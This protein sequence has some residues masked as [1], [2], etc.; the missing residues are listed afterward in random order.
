MSQGENKSTRFNSRAASSNLPNTYAIHD[1]DL[2]KQFI[3]RYQSI[4]V[5]FVKVVIC[6]NMYLRGTQVIWEE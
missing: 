5:S 3:L 2:L 4:A 6:E 1:Y